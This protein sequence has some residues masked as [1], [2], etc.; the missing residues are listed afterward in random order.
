MHPHIWFFWFFDIYQALLLLF[1]IA[2]NYGK[3]MGLSA[4]DLLSEICFICNASLRL[5]VKSLYEAFVLNNFKKS[6]SR[7]NDEL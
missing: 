5:R 6:V 1:R 4:S 3:S 7:W 2:N